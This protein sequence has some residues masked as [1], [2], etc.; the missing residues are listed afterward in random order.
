MKAEVNA[1]IDDAK[2][3]TNARFDSTDARIEEVR[4]EGRA[5]DAILADH[6]EAL[7]RIEANQESNNLRKQ[8]TAVWIGIAVAVIAILINIIMQLAG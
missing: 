3:E 2:A 1:R 5:R 7:A 6:T 4:A 8:L